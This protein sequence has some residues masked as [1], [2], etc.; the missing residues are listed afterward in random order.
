MATI[1]TVARKL[2]VTAFWGLLVL[3]AGTVAVV[4]VIGVHDQLV[5]DRDLGCYD[6]VVAAARARVPERP[7]KRELS[8][9]EVR[10]IGLPVDPRPSP[11]NWRA[12]AEVISQEEWEALPDTEAVKACAIDVTSHGAYA[13]NAWSYRNREA[14]A[15]PDVGLSF[16]ALVPLGLLVALNRWIRWLAR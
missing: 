1:Q 7:H 5:R 12:E 8:D 11:T 16:L 2:Y 10:R 6:R 4:G 13:E 15:L 9:E 3:G 14:R